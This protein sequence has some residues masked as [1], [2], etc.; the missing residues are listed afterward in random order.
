MTTT[1]PDASQERRARD[2]SVGILLRRRQNRLTEIAE[3]RRR[4]AQSGFDIAAALELHLDDVPT[5]RGMIALLESWLSEST[6]SEERD[7]QYV[8]AIERAIRVI[9]SA[10]DLPTGIAMLQRAS[11]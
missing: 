11:D 7:E 4:K 6:Q 3:D 2:R 5:R 1:Q 10:P 8:Q 9:K